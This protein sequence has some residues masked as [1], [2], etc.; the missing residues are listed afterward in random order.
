MENKIPIESLNLCLDLLSYKTIDNRLH[1]ISD[2]NFIEFTYYLPNY[3]Y[4]FNRI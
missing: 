1:L 4:Y 3:S 2:Y